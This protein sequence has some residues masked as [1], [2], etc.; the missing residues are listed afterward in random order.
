[1]TKKIAL[2]L[3]KIDP[4][5]ERENEWNEWYNNTHI[6][7]RLSLPGFLS[8]RRYTKMENLPNVTTMAGEPKYFALYD[9]ANVN[10]LNNEYYKKLREKELARGPDSFDVTI[11]KLPKFARGVYEQIYPENGEYKV[12]PSKYLFVVG[13]DIPRNKRKEFDA[14]YNT[15]HIPGLLKISGFLS[16]RRFI[17]TQRPSPPIV[18][19]GSTLPG[20]LS[21][22]DIENVNALETDAFAKVTSTPWTL[23]VR[24]WYTRRMRMV[25]RQIYPK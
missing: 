15:E 25:Y 1:M 7:A 13:H 3:V 16:A 8:A 20:F 6:A 12:P 24:S 21:V 9:M 18:E 19:H 22:Y 2:L 23:W 4:P 17:L 10:L 5:K 11:S 14:W